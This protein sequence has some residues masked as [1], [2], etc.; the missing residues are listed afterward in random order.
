[1]ENLTQKSL[2]TELKE[3]AEAARRIG[4]TGSLLQ[5][6]IEA[7]IA[8]QS[9]TPGTPEHAALMDFHCMCDAFIT[10]TNN[11]RSQNSDL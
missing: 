11:L 2:L 8:M 1:M 10:G 5:I 7:E 6:K 9:V 3:K 4:D